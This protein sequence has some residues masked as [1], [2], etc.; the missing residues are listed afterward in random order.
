MADNNKATQAPAQT[1]QSRFSRLRQSALLASAM[2]VPLPAVGQE[3]VLNEVRQPVAPVVTLAQATIPR[4]DLDIGSAGKA[5]VTYASPE[6][7]RGAL[8]MFDVNSGPNRPE[9]V[10]MMLTEIGLLPSMGQERY[11]DTIQNF[12]ADAEQR[13]IELGRDIAQLVR[14]AAEATGK[15]ELAQGVEILEDQDFARNLFPLTNTAESMFLRAARAHPAIW[16]DPVG[17]T[18]KDRG[19]ASKKAAFII[20]STENLLPVLEAHFVDPE[21]NP[22]PG[23]PAPQPQ[24]IPINFNMDVDDKPGVWAAQ[25][26]VFDAS[27]QAPLTLAQ[28]T[29]P[30][31]KT[32]GERG[33][34]CATYASSIHPVGGIIVANVGMSA[35]GLRN[36]E[37]PGQ[38]PVTEGDVLAGELECETIDDFLAGVEARAEQFGRDMASLARRVAEGVGQ[39]DVAAGVERLEAEGFGSDLSEASRLTREYF[40]RIVAA[41]EGVDPSRLQE[42]VPP[43]EMQAI[44]QRGQQGDT[45]LNLARN[46]RAQLANLEA[47]FGPRVQGVPAGVPIRW[48]SGPD[49]VIEREARV[50][51]QG[52]DRTTTASNDQGYRP[53]SLTA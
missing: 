29:E 20:E 1:G 5:C 40:D 41:A 3:A 32:P 30:A 39:P 25:N 46:A 35:H 4:A 16:Q 21:A 22:F 6:V 17:Q 43:E 24:G 53:R 11:C 51:P 36:V 19:I 26:A 12:R 50:E 52:V 38:H 48:Q 45:E 27:V 2:A 18:I 34:V 42:I 28:V 23:L 31:P 13:S 15:P 9:I 7:P 49:A 37:S 33:Y 44:M 47:Q 10:P 8:I 14:Q